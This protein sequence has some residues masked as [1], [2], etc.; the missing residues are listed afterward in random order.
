M[1]YAFV[2]FNTTRLSFSSVNTYRA[3]SLT[4]GTWYISGETDHLIRSLHAHIKALSVS[5]GNNKAVDICWHVFPL[6]HNLLLFS[7]MHTKKDVDWSQNTGM[8]I[9]TGSCQIVQGVG[10]LSFPELYQLL[11]PTDRGD[12][13][14][15]TLIP[16]PQTQ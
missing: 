5:H 11:I 16:L 15:V 9:F 1:P 3:T 13:V 8:L 14:P 4:E 10:Y 7:V 6:E 2:M 12:H